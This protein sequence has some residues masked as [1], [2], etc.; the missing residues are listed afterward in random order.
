M[1]N[2]KFIIAA[3]ALIMASNL[4]FSQKSQKRNVKLKVSNI[5]ANA[6][7]II[8]SAHNSEES[9]KKR[10]PCQTLNVKAQ[11]PSVEIALSLESGEYVFC[12]YHDTNSDGELNA[13]LFGIPKEPFAFSNYDG[14]S[15]PGNFKKHKVNI[16]GGSDEIFELEIKLFTF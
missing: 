12:A 13:G 10:K 16:P 6:G 15:P 14:K 9:F 4:S 11:A 8:I 5:G 2:K 7:N 1:K 3:L